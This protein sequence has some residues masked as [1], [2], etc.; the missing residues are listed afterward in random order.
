MSFPVLQLFFLGLWPGYE[1]LDFVVTA[2]YGGYIEKRIKASA[3][4]PG[5][6]LTLL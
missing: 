5:P 4:Y 1:S 6:R 2:A 3:I